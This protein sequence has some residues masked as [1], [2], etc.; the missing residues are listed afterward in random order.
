MTQV[1]R[2][3]HD[4]GAGRMSMSDL[5]RARRELKAQLGMIPEYTPARV[6]VES[7]LEAVNTELAKRGGDDPFLCRQLSLEQL[8]R[9]GVVVTRDLEKCT[10]DERP[11]LQAHRE[12]I[13]SEIKRRETPV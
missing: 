1:V 12:A 13:D 3:Q 10:P 5:L 2:G 8:Y 11:R 7:E 4:Y 6:P 9:V